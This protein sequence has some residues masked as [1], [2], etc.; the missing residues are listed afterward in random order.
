MR[1]DMFF[2][3]FSVTGLR[4]SERLRPLPS[5]I[6]IRYPAHKITIINLRTRFGAL[7]RLGEM[8]LI[9]RRGFAIMNVYPGVRCS[10]PVMVVSG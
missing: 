7:P 3:F 5:Y 1:L 9:P 10:S 2:F 4:S 6:P 8:N